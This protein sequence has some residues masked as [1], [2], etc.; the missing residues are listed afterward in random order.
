MFTPFT[1]ITN[2]PTVPTAIPGYQNL[3]ILGQFE[4]YKTTLYNGIAKFN[5]AGDVDT[6]FNM[7]IGFNS[8]LNDLIQQPDGTLVAVGS[9]TR[10]SGSS[11]NRIV[12]LNQNGTIDAQFKVGAGFNGDPYAVMRQSDGKLVCVGTFTSYSGSTRRGIARI[13]TDGTL[14]ASFPNAAVSGSALA[15]VVQQS[16]GKLILAGWITGYSGSA[17]NG[18]VRV[19]TNGVIDETFKVGTGVAA[20]SLTAIAIQSDDKIIIG[21]SFTSYSGSLINRIA[22]I[23]TDGTLDTTYKV[24]T[25]LSPQP[26][27]GFTIQSDG[28]IIVTVLS[29]VTYSGSALAGPIVRIN[30]DGTRDLTFTSSFAMGQSN[31]PNKATSVASDGTIYHA[32]SSPGTINNTY[33]QGYLMRMTSTGNRDE[34]FDIGYSLPSASRGFVKR[35]QSPKGMVASGSGGAFIYGPYGNIYKSFPYRGIVA[36]D[37][38]GD[39]TSSIAGDFNIKVRGTASADG[40]GGGFGAGTV[41]KAYKTTNNKIV[42]CGTFSAWGGG[43]QGRIIRILSDGNRDSALRIGAGAN[44][45]VQDIAV[46]SSTQQMVLVGAF[47]TYSGSTATR[48]VKINE[49]GSID[50]SFKVGAGFTTEPRSVAIQSDGKV[51]VG[52]GGNYSQSIQVPRLVRI[53]T[54]GTIDT[55]FSSSAGTGPNAIP[56]WIIPQPDN[57]ILI[58]TNFTSYNGV[59]SQYICRVNSDGTRDTDFKVGVGFNGN[60]SALT[61]QSDGKIMALGSFTSYSGS[62]IAGLA[63]LNSSGSLD[64]T[65]NPGTGLSSPYDGILP[66]SIAQDADGSYYVGGSF[67]T[68]QGEIFHNFVVVTS[69]GAIDTTYYRGTTSFNGTGSIG[70]PDKPTSIILL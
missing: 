65:F 39:P 30:T 66:G 9:F 56:I 14:D 52:H 21:G 1:F 20:N 33:Y 45:T 69:T 48:I 41:Y 16:D 49:F 55:A 13:N 26:Y 24:G 10:Y 27:G 4:S 62:A 67:R 7:G 25:G 37:K 31:T 44:N 68:Y 58:G 3:V 6:S 29:N 23:N 36:I 59:S 42:A 8:S 57:K 54:D 61:L 22:R 38:T 60:I 43:S 34:G 28:K 50:T 40:S 53:N 32:G 64:T 12:K 51:L 18:L 15:Q 35:N 2:D 63:R 17:R 19:N 70:F 47:G 11:Y 5:S 46:D